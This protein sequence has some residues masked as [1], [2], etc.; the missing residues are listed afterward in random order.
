M[1]PE[2]ISRNE[3]SE[4]ADIYSF[5]VVLT[6]M[7]TSLSPYSDTTLFPQQIMYAVVN[8]GL[9]PSVGSDCPPAMDVLIKDCLNSEPLLRP[10]FREIKERLKRMQF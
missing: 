6:E 8:E 9:R 4:K 1:A 10:D 7:V 2:V 3:I 5:G